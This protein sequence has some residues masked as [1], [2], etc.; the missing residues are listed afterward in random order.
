MK[1][2]QPSTSCVIDG[3]T[4]RPLKATGPSIFPILLHICNP[5]IS[6]REFPNCWKVGR[7]TPLYKSSVKSDPNSFQPISVLPCLGKLLERQIHNQVYA[8]LTI[9][10]V[11]SDQQSGFRKALLC[12]HVSHRTSSHYF[13]KY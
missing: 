2:L 5:S 1:D 7:I 9:H 6:K 10:N 4:A 11:L 8:Y 3:I 12:W 13:F